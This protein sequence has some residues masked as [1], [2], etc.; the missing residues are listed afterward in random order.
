VKDLDVPSGWIGVCNEMS[1]RKARIYMSSG[2]VIVIK[3]RDG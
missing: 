2:K 3:A 1:G